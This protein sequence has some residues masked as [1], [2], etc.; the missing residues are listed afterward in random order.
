MTVAMDSPLFPLNI[1]DTQRMS[2]KK[3]FLG[4]ALFIL[5]QKLWYYRKA[6]AEKTTFESKLQ[7]NGRIEFPRTHA[8]VLHHCGLYI[9]LPAR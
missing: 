4:T 8:A 9:W 5:R 1:F 7:E 6:N 3:I 2:Y